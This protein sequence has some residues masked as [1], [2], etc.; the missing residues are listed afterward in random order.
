MKRAILIFVLSLFAL[1]CLAKTL[2]LKSPN[3]MTV[4]K[5]NLIK[6]EVSRMGYHNRWMVISGHRSE[7]YNSRLP[8]ANKESYHLKGMAIDIYVF[9]INGNWKFDREDISILM[10]ANDEV[11][12]KNP[13]LVGAFG[14]Y[15]SGGYFT[16]RM[17][18]FDTRGFKRK[19]NI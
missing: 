7:W 1:T 8:N 6:E 3:D 11:E 15:L 17:I 4:K 2:I 18:H 12:R 16:K 19:Y 10:K 9:D 14:T 13:K 5:L